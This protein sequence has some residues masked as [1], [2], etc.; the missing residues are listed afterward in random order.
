MTP[1]QGKTTWDNLGQLGQA[2]IYWGWACPKFLSQ[3]R[4]GWDT[5]VGRS[6]LPEFLSQV[7]KTWDTELGR[8]KPF[9]YAVVP[10]VP[11]CPNPFQVR[12]AP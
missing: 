6:P 10:S 12:C 1:T 9:V 8:A 4:W 5:G 7:G 2:C 3:V 11:T